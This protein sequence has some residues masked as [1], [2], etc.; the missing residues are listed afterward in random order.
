MCAIRRSQ[1]RRQ[2]AQTLSPDQPLLW[3]QASIHRII[4]LP[5]LCL[6]FWAWPELCTGYGDRLP[7]APT[8]ASTRPFP[9]KLP[10]ARRFAQALACLIHSPVADCFNCVWLLQ[11]YLVALPVSACLSCGWSLI[12]ACYRYLAC[13]AIRGLCNVSRLCCLPAMPG[14]SSACVE[15][16]ALELHCLGP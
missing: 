13:N 10:F 2:L 15:L 9:R 8:V 12:R 16:I 14:R 7:P 6:F 4:S 5:L 3:Q 11:L 1:N